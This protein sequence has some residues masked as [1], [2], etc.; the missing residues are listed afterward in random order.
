MISRINIQSS[1]KEDV[2]K[3]IDILLELGSKGGKRFRIDKKDDG[4]I[5]SE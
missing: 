3:A 2:Q 1:K 5:W 4:I